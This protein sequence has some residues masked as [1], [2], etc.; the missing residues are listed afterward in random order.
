MSKRTVI[1][2]VICTVILVAASVTTIHQDPDISGISITSN[3]DIN[4]NEMQSLPGT[5]EF[6]DP[7]SDIYLVILVKYLT[8]DDRI[9]VRWHFDK[10]GKYGV[11][12]QDS[13]T[14]GNKGSGKIVISLAKKDNRHPEGNYRVEVILNGKQKV[15]K[16]FSVTGD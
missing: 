9:I 10:N 13:I 11:V 6:K 12:Q 2:L 5:V 4:E 3:K 7:A 1:I 16:T 8:T 14:P 15:S